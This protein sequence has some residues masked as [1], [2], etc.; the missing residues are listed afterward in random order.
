MPVSPSLLRIYDAVDSAIAEARPRCDASGRCCRFDEW[1]HTLF[2]TA[3]EAER[4]FSEPFP[5]GGEVAA[6]RCPYQV[7]GRCV[8]RERRPLGCRIYFCD[9]AWAER[10]PAVMETALAELRALHEA[11]GMAWD[12]RP[13]H[14]WSPLAEA[15]AAA[16][17]DPL[18]I[19]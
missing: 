17:P 16:P 11:E 2:L 14:R 4:L 7:G 15:L 8:A 3:P 12:Y 5:P 18:R 10:M 13:L 9:P 19:L 6:D 1:G